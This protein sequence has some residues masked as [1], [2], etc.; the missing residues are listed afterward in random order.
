MVAMLLKNICDIN[1]PDLYWCRSTTAQTQTSGQAKEQAGEG[2]AA[3]E[4][5]H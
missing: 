2:A 5:E 3:N 1:E 4:N